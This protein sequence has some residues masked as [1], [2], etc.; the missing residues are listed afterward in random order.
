MTLGTMFIVYMAVYTSAYR[1][2]PSDR[3]WEAFPHPVW[4][5]HQCLKSFGPCMAPL[6]THYDHGIPETRTTPVSFLFKDIMF[7]ECPIYT[8]FPQQMT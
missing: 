5:S 2:M 1:G 4:A 6:Y 7:L 3:E 8:P